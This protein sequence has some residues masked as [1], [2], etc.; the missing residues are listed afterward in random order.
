MKGE[1]GDFL[2][3]ESLTL[4]PIDKRPIDVEMLTDEERQ[5]LDDYHQLVFDRLSPH[6]TSD[7]VAWLR[8]ACAPVY[9]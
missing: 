2:Q 1:F 8:E 9:V 7:E 4:C 6:L 3:F 5:W